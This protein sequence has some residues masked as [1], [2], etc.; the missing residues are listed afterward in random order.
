M[1]TTRQGDLF[2]AVISELNSLGYQGQL[3]QRDYRFEDW[4]SAR[5]GQTA[6]VHTADAV[7]FGRSPLSYESACFALARSNGISGPDLVRRYRAVGAPLAFEVQND[8]VLLWRVH[9]TTTATSKPTVILPEEIEAAFRDNAEDWK[10][11]KLLRAKNIGPV[12]PRQRD[13]I[14]IGLIPALEE[15]I[16][17]KLDPFLRS[18]F[19]EARQFYQQRHPSATRKDWL[20]RLV[21]RA[22]AG[23]VMTDRR[24]RGFEGFAK[25]P[26]PDAL[27]AAVNK[28]FGDAPQP[29]ADAETRRL[30]V[31]RF[32]KSFSFYHISV[33]VL[34]FVWENTLVDE[35]VRKEY[36]LHGTP[37]SV[38]R[39][40][41]KRLSFERIPDERRYVVEPCCGSATF[42]LAAMRQ[43]TDLLPPTY[44]DEQRHV[45]LQQRLSGFDIDEFGLEVAR[46]CL[47]L[48]DY[49][50]SNHW[51]L[52]DEDVFLPPSQSPRYHESLRK[53][54]VVLCNPPFGKF[55]IEAKK[56]Y[57]AQSIHKP[58][59][60]LSRVLDSLPSDGTLG[61]VLPYLLLTGQSYPELR[62]RLAERFGSIEVVTL[63]DR[64]VFS[65]A[66]YETAVLIASEPRASGTT[67]NILHRNV[68]VK[69]WPDFDRLGKVPC[70]DAQTKSVDEAKDSFNI[71][72][73]QELW[74]YLQD[75]PKVD[76]ATDGKVHRGVE[77]TISIEDDADILLSDEPKDGYKL[78]IPPAKKTEFYSFL[79]PALKY[80]CVLPE[81]QRRGFNWR[82]DFPKVVMNRRRKSRSPWRVAAFADETGLFCPDKFIGL[83]PTG[84]WRL[85]VLSAA[86]NGPVA[87]AYISTHTI[88]RDIPGEVIKQV[89]LPRLDG[90]LA[91]RIEQLVD[92]YVGLVRDD[93][94][95]PDPSRSAERVLLEIDAAVLEGYDLPPRLERRLLDYFNGYGHR[96]PINH[97]FGDYF[98]EDFRPCFSLAEY[99]SEGFRL[100][101][102]K[103]FKT[104]QQK[105]PEEM[106]RALRSVTGIDRE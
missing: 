82:W 16:L 19:F 71:P 101:T 96:R 84:R 75:H 7:A 100:S 93:S 74:Q 95:P 67:T 23:K 18:T 8:K 83:W 53:A 1:K 26:D 61:F 25:A 63:P 32:W 77:W 91:T 17:E 94:Q 37:P 35:D 97:A 30:V 105:P 89:P 52:K 72:Y 44:S 14:D 12:G 49:P 9:A 54:G 41:V 13:F 76:G 34:S 4:F 62:Q 80:L 78:G 15:N 42:L 3:L 27:L 31:D 66:K 59:E 29:L 106:L 58:V 92:E 40:I 5:A 51:M 69:E 56:G 20:F 43:L 38:A 68:N 50:N 85:K 57:K 22:L 88:G 10:R 2:E 6:E 103:E 104:R 24:L 46:D 55:T 98:P 47:M 90:K 65:S 64:G 28:H 11:E 60:L 79:Q 33:P 99:L 39:Y 36:G 102:A 86:M 87:N 48:A 70:G 45:Y 81:Y 21:F 73:L